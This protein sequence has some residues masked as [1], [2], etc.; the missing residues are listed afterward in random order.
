VVQGRRRIGKSRLI[1]EFAKQYR[2][3]SFA[4]IVPTKNTTAQTEKDESAKQLSTNLNYQALKS[5]DWSDLF[6]TLARDTKDG[7]VVILF[8]E[9]SWM[10][11]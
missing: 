3:L 11:K 7:R 9:V 1:K 8:D 10:G 5:S 4:G 6:S 2:F